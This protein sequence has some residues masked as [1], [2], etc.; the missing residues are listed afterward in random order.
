[1]KSYRRRF[2]LLLLLSLLLHLMVLWWLLDNWDA[3]KPPPAEIKTVEITLK[4]GAK[5]EAPPVEPVPAEPEEEPPESEPEAEKKQPEKPEPEPETEPIPEQKAIPEAAP[6]PIDNAD[7]FSSNNQED[8]SKTKVD[9]G[10]AVETEKLD[11]NTLYD[12]VKSPDPIEKPSTSSEM[13]EILEKLL[14]QPVAPEVADKDQESVTEILTTESDQS[15]LRADQEPQTEK[16]IIEA[17]RPVDQ[18]LSGTP[19]PDESDVQAGKIFTTGDSP[20]FQLEIP[21][22]FFEGIGNMAMIS[23]SGTSN[24]GT[25]RMASSTEISNR[26]SPLE[27]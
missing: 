13:N 9:F 3:P 16:A 19:T 7:E 2:A 22:E 11:E 18:T 20:S 15:D 25:E 5:P 23:L 26:V 10:T 6:A 8:Q 27:M 12:Q 14:Q 4:P 24:R 17:E 21:E 1:M